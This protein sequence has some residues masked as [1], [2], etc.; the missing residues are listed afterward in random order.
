MASSSQLADGILRQEQ[1]SQLWSRL[2]QDS[3][4]L[5]AREADADKEAEA[6]LLPLFDPDKIEI[7]LVDLDSLLNSWK[8]LPSHAQAKFEKKYGKIATLLQVKI[9]V[10]AL[11]AMLSIW[12]PKYRVFSFQ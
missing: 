8:S 5:Q 9:Q 6:H 12:N 10:P 7:R 2:I 4:S 11:K 1:N 3:E